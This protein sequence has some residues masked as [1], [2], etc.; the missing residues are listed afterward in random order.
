M[1]DY[2]IVYKYYSKKQNY[3]I[4]LKVVQKTSNQ[5]RI[6]GVIF[7]AKHIQHRFKN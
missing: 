4:I 6:K 3:V 5:I 7:Y 1:D 2:K